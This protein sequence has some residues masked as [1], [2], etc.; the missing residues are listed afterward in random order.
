M[1]S[2]PRAAA[3]RGPRFLQDRSRPRFHFPCLTILRTSARPMPSS[4]ARGHRRGIGSSQ[5]PRCR[6]ANAEA[7]PPFGAYHGLRLAAPWK[8]PCATRKHRL[9][10]SHAGPGRDGPPS[11]R[12]HRHR[13]RHHHRLHQGSPP[14]APP[15]ASPWLNAPLAP[16]IRGSSSSPSSSPRLAQ[17]CAFR[18]RRA[19]S[20]A[21]RHLP[22]PGASRT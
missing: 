21:Q 11:P 19:F 18:R 9:A 22:S 10:T 2:R 4:L 8:P 17:T 16:V 5:W 6:R 3:R 14:Q 15:H 1:A 7:T 12:S 20:R 13:R